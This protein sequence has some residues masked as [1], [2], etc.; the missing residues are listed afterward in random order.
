MAETGYNAGA[1]L[2][3]NA[4]TAADQST[5]AA[6]QSVEIEKHIHPRSSGTTPNAIVRSGAI[7]IA[8]HNNLENVVIG[9]TTYIF[10][11]SLGSPGANEVHIKI[12]ANVKASVLMMLKA[13]QGNEDVDNILFN[14]VHANAE[15]RVLWTGQEYSLNTAANSPLAKSTDT[16]TL[17]LLL[18]EKAEDQTGALTLTSTTTSSIIAFDRFT[19]NKYTTVANG[20]RGDYLCITGLNDPDFPTVGPFGPFR[21]DV[22]RV[23]VSEGS[24]SLSTDSI[25]M[26]FYYSYDEETFTKMSE[27]LNLYRPDAKEALQFSIQQQRPP[28]GA[29]VYVKMAS[30]SDAA[31]GGTLDFSIAL[32]TYPIGV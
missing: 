28:L 4:Q 7:R 22:N 13:I 21:F 6:T 12:Q 26:D 15:S 9:S 27:G 23:D 32:H 1:D 20:I 31:A 8:S 3:T 16:S 17:T 19:T 10:V 2:E 24:N 18:R 14:S 29:G 5:I 25:E 30:P 11:T